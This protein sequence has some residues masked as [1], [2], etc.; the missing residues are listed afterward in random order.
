MTLQE[1]YDQMNGSYDDAKARLMMDSMIERFL[2]KFLED[3]TMEELRR[4]VASGDIPGSFRQA[5]TLK[6]V[7]ANLAFTGLQKA[8]SDLT[9]QLRPQA[10]PADPKLMAQVEGA[11]QAVVEAIHAYQTGR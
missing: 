10:A 4:A 2:Q 5:H 6:G 1:C 11:Y 9:E 8:A 3:K 7:A